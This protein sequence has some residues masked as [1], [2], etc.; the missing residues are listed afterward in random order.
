MISHLG[1]GLPD[2]TLL[3]KTTNMEPIQFCYWLQGFVELN[4]SGKP[5]GELQ[6]KIIQDHLNAVFEKKTPTYNHPAGIA[7]AG[8]PVVNN[9]AVAIC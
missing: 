5:P 4:T 9:Q 7:V 1:M 3:K 2:P 8:I 6:W